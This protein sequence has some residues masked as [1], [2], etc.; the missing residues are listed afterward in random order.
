MQSNAVRKSEI[1]QGRIP[2]NSSSG[3]HPN[4]AILRTRAFALAKC[5]SRVRGMSTEFV[6]DN[7]RTWESLGLPSY[8]SDLWPV[9]RRDLLGDD[10]EHQLRSLMIIMR[11]QGVMKYIWPHDTLYVIRPEHNT[12]LKLHEL[13]R[14]Q[15]GPVIFVPIDIYNRHAGKSVVD[16][17]SD[18]EEHE[19]G[20]GSF[21]Q[22][23]A[24]LWQR[25]SLAG[26]V[27]HLACVGDTYRV[28]MGSDTKSAPTFCTESHDPTARGKIFYSRVHIEELDHKQPYQV[29]TGFV[30][31]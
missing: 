16:I 27:L 23:C 5:V 31:E 12:V 4:A 24:L 1:A 14:M 9:L 25:D 13:E 8:A 30:P 3:E 17:R 28:G 26:Q 11:E 21:E 15:R 10:Y 18:M 6:D 20:L 29:V 7:I 19:F 2:H 22:G